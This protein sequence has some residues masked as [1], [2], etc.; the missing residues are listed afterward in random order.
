MTDSIKQIEILLVE[1]NPGDVFL[2]KHAFS[3]ARISNNI[4]VASD[5]EQAMD[6]LYKRGDFEDAKTPDLILLD[7]NMPKKDGREV[8]EEVK[9]NAE[10]LTIPVV[11]LTSSKADKDIAQTY[12]LHAN[13]YL[14]KP[15]DMEEFSDVVNAVENF[16]FSAALLPKSN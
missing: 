5:G 15:V 10:L 4:S 8:L 13:S 12:S 3:E 6:F 9:T 7:L 1:D 14:V 16:W 11:I 2:T